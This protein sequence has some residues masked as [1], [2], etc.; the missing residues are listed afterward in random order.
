M[1]Q[2]PI[3]LDTDHSR[4]LWQMLNAIPDEVLLDYL[5]DHIVDDSEIDDIT[6]RIALLCQQ[7]HT[8]LTITQEDRE[9]LR[10]MVHH[11][12]EHIRHQQD[13]EDRIEAK[14]GQ[15]S[16][17]QVT[18]VMGGLLQSG[19]IAIGDHAVAGDPQSGHIP[20]ERPDD[21]DEEAPNP[22]E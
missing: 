17:Q 5:S 10:R 3:S 1:T 4:R 9:L 18:Q 20:T 12:V 14:M 13:V 21:Y 22:V 6:Q 8:E 11:S 7:H 2:D 15:I 16:L 19:H